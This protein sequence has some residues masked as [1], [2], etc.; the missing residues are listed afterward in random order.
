MRWYSGDHRHDDSLQF[1]NFK[2]RLYHASLAAVLSPLR[3]GMTTPVVRRCPDRHFRCVLYDLLAFIADYH[4]QVMLVGIVQGW[5][6][7]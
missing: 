3:R 1:H 7:K 5:C 4:E 2:R 6:P